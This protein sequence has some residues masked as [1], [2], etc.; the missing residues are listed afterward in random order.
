MCKKIVVAFFVFRLES[1]G[2][3]RSLAFFLSLFLFLGPNPIRS[4]KVRDPTGSGYAC[5]GEN[6]SVIG[7]PELF[8]EM[9]EFDRQSSAAIVAFRKSYFPL[10]W[11]LPR[12]KSEVDRAGLRTTRLIC[13]RGNL[14]P[15]LLP[16]TSFPQTLTFV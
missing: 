12:R 6:N 10:V 1:L 9:I 16:S 3:I 14:P 2:C 7:F 8:C 11:I 13:P 15:L 5:T 4:S